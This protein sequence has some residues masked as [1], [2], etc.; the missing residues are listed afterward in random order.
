MIK[1]TFGVLAWDISQ[2]DD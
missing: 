1:Y 2:F